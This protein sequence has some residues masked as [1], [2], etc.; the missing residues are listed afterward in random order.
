MSKLR[1]RLS[2]LLVL[3][4]ASF[5]LVLVN[6]SPAQA[7]TYGPYPAK[8][9]I[10]GRGS[11]DPNDRVK[12]DAYLTGSPVHV[13]CQDTG[14]SAGGSTLWIYTS[15][16][17]WIPDAY[18]TTGT[19]GYLPG[20][21]RCIAIG[22]NGVPR[23]GGSNA[24]P[25]PAKFD[26]DGRGS[27]NPDDRIRVDA[28]LEGSQVYVRCQDYGIAAGGSTLWIYTTDGY[29]IPD[30]YVTTGTDGRLPGVP[31]CLSIGINGGH[32]G[33][34]GGGQQFLARTTLNGYHAKSLSASNV[35]D[36]YPE[37]TY[38]TVMCQAYGEVNY[39][40]SNLWN[41]TSDGLWVADYYVRTGTNGMVMN[42]CDN[43][44]GSGGGNRYLVKETLNGYY[45]KSLTA[46][47]V[48][49]KYLKGS[50]ITIEC[51]AYGEI[52]Y[53]GHAVWSYT[54]DKLWVADYYVYTGSWDITMRRCDN[55]PKPGGGSNPSAPGSPPT[56]S[57]HSSKIRG[58]IV[59][60]ANSQLGLHEWGD[61][62]NPYGRTDN[63]VCGL[64]WCSM[65]AS[66]TWRQAGINVYFPYTGDF[67]TWGR[68]HG[69]LRSK[70]NI[71]PGDLV[72]YGT[73]YYASH[74]I[75]VV[76]DVDS[77]GKI[78]TIEGNYGNQVKKVGPF[79]PYNPSPVHSYSNIYAVVAP[80]NDGS[81]VWESGTG[82]SQ[83]NCTTLRTKGGVSY[84]LCLEFTHT[85]QSSD[86]RWTHT[87]AR[88]VATA[89]SG[90][91]DVVQASLSLSN[92]GGSGDTA[93]CAGALLRSGAA[94]RCE[95]AQVN[96]SSRGALTVTGNFWINGQE[97]TTLRVVD[98]KLIGFEQENA[99]T[100][101]GPAAMKSAIAT[102]RTA[103]VPSQSTLASQ[104][105]T[106]S[107]GTMPWKLAETLSI[108][109]PIA[110][111][112]YTTYTWAT[113]A[114]RGLGLELGLDHIRRQL[115]KG[116]PSIVVVQPAYLPWSTTGNAQVRH[117]L[118][119]HGYTSAQQSGGAVPW[120]M[121]SLQV[122]DPGTGSNHRI[123]VDELVHAAR[124]AAGLGEID[125]VTPKG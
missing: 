30:A 13:R 93:F 122:W 24:G 123:S 71:R 74:H 4:F 80:V 83:A 65:F 92:D 56:G 113:Y 124:T 60:A 23:T 62:C 96:L 76:V 59:Q 16:G 39:G 78:T 19:D 8:F 111:T 21:P 20:V 64:P 15:T 63:V 99:A 116:Q 43:D 117:Y 68:N 46:A 61:N 57:V 121:G 22:I 25:Y 37:G 103:S 9:A 7:R 1:R 48:E 2:A 69:L 34:S 10:D 18:V 114:D 118:M 75:G 84:W 79:D 12:T 87:K 81:Q 51:Q 106:G 66:W 115:D 45:A 36:K 27:A 95:T 90:G 52:N 41:Y 88:A 53:G 67:E 29:W 3:T 102:M 77:T 120:P 33:H 85:W 110:G 32:G 109:T 86:R 94:R 125:V 14:L 35:W 73:S 101:C 31:S 26:I 104:S 100:Y 82:T 17:Y 6:A 55:D 108:H 91:S 42:R 11:M 107:L 105:G 54:S 5:S 28:Y 47:R 44:G 112:G 98:L 72:I 89:V 97:Q 38:I 40:G 50:Y 58:A 49:D 70:G 119:I